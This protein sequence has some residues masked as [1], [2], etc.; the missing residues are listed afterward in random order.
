MKEYS[1]KVSFKVSR[2]TVD[3]Y[4]HEKGQG[5][6]SVSKN[7]MVWSSYFGS[8]GLDST[9]KDFVSRINGEY[10]ANNLITGKK[11]VFN[12]RNTFKQLRKFLREDMCLYWYEHMTFQKDMRSKIK[13]FSQACDDE[14]DFV[15]NFDFY[16]V[17]MQNFDLIENSIDS[18]QV[19]KELE[20]IN[21]P[22][23]FIETKYS[24]EYLMLMKLHK[25]IVAKINGG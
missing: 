18:H 21:E 11:F 15:N 8:I 19:R 9:M 23:H 16:M 17:A 24:S 20:S 14:Q 1:S 3:I 10:F 7:G 25:K 12:K 2:F 13:A 6:I 4:D 5:T 22:W